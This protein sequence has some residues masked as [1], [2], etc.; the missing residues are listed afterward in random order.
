MSR[1]R[2]PAWS[3]AE[4]E[5]ASG[6]L[7]METSPQYRLTP[8]GGRRGVRLRPHYSSLSV[9]PH[10][11]AV[12]GTDQASNPSDPVEWAWTVAPFHKNPL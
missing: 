11:F 4:T 8:P 6:I 3:P 1:L 12:T 9:G 5:A 2:N 7:A 10:T